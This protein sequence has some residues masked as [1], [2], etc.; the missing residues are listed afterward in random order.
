MPR[1]VFIF[2][3]ICIFWLG[4]NYLIIF[5][6]LLISHVQYPNI[7]TTSSIPL[8]Y[9]C[10]YHSLSFVSIF[11]LSAHKSQQE[12]SRSISFINFPLDFMNLLKMKVL[13]FFGGERDL[14]GSSIMCGIWD[15]ALNM[16]GHCQHSLYFPQWRFRG[17]AFSNTC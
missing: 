1:E 7:L 15:R 16:A 2:P 10:L 17:I 6:F 9:C 14:L 11:F 13:I 4:L 12:G 8:K 3:H 5:L